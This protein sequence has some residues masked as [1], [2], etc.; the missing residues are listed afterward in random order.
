M[1]KKLYSV[2]LDVGLVEDIDR[3]SSFMGLTRSA[4]VQL[5]L[6]SFVDGYYKQAAEMICFVADEAMQGDGR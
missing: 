2:S 4:L 3:V 6:K 5:V 1:G